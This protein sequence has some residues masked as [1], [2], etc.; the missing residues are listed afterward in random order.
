MLIIAVMP[1][2]NED[3]KCA[4]PSAIR[5]QSGR[6]SL[7]LNLTHSGWGPKEIVS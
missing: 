1:V 5:K 4:A 3:D 2:S 7:C 6:R